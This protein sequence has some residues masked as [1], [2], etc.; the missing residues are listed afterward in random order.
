[1]AQWTTTRLRYTLTTLIPVCA[2]LASMIT[3]ALFLVPWVL[4]VLLAPESALL[5]WLHGGAAVTWLVLFLYGVK[6]EYR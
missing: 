4:F 3:G 5:D 2:L 1:M 6:P